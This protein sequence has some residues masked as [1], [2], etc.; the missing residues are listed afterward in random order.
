MKTVHDE[1]E[2]EASLKEEFDDIQN[3]IAAQKGDKS[4]QDGK[5]KSDDSTDGAS[6]KEADEEDKGT[7]NASKDSDKDQTSKDDDD[8]KAQDDEEEPPHRER[9]V[10]PRKFQNLKRILKETT[11]AK[12]GEIARLTQELEAAKG[13]KETDASI[14]EF[15]DKH[16]M[17]EEMVADL[18]KIAKGKT[19]TLDSATLESVKKAELFA[20][21][22][23]AIEAFENEFSDLVKELPD[24]AAHADLIRKEAY[25]ESNLNRSLYEIFNRF[26]K[27]NVSQTRKTG[28]T[29]RGPSGV[30]GNKTFN[31]EG[32]AAKIKSGA[33]GAFDGL[34]GDQIDA[35]FEHM[36]K[37]GSRFNR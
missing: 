23:E 37:T 21:K 17:S 24:A 34:T 8:D 4:N 18:I 22:Q 15:A 6:D 29:T 31:V 2:S 33:A 5:E 10:P 7:D 12:D 25:K 30:R 11:E 13:S 1:K 32:V 36:D 3:E 19:P 16:S 35:V 20:K 27:P 9:G 26:V 14:K 28:E